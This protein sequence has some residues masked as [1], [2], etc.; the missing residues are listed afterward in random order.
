MSGGG[1]ERDQLIALTQ[2]FKLEP[3]ISF[4]G[5]VKKEELEWFFQTAHI[6]I[7]PKWWIEYTSVLLIEA[8]AHGLPCIIPRGG[9][10][11]WL[12]QTGSFNF[13][14][15]SIAGL[16]EQIEI[17]GRDAQQRTALAQNNLAKAQ[18]LDYG[19]LGNR[20]A[21]IIQELPSKNR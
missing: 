4:P 15:D 14:E 6:F 17:L 8:M 13:M 11:E 20:L 12:A 7:L 1:P 2:K 9:G 16:K 10:L 5:W 18:E 21:N 3:F 19:K